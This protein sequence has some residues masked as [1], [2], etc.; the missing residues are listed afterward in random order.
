MKRLHANA[1]VLLEHWHGYAR[2]LGIN[3][4]SR[5]AAEE[6]LAF[7]PGENREVVLAFYDASQKSGKSTSNP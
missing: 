7:L 3:W 1:D 2:R 4:A 5:E 6:A